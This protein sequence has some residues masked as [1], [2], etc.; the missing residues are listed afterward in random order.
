MHH[1]IKWGGWYLLESSWYPYPRIGLKFGIW[2]RAI[3]NRF[4]LKKSLTEGINKSFYILPPN[5]FIPF[6]LRRNTFYPRL[7][8]ALSKFVNEMKRSNPGKAKS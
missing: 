1:T 8:I 2:N 3:I 5:P 7:P 6:Y 4:F